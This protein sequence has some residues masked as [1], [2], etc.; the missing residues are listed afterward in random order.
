[1][2]DRVDKL[3]E[4]LGNSEGFTSDEYHVIAELISRTPIKGAEAIPVAMIQQKLNRILKQSPAPPVGSNGND[5]P[6]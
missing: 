2:D 1:M 4:A 3:K 5:Q 6:S